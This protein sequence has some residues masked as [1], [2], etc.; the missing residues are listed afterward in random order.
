MLTAK[1]TSTSSLSDMKR[2]KLIGLINLD[3]YLIA[4]LL[5]LALLL[6]L[7][8]AEMADLEE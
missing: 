6:L 4:L 7:A 5:S 1:K 2:T 8:A 3:E